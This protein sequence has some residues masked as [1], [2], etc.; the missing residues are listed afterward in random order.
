MLASVPIPC[1][2][3]NEISSLSVKKSGADVCR[4]SNLTSS[5]GKISLIVNDGNGS[6][7]DTRFQDIIEVKP[8][9]TTFL[10]DKENVS[11]DDSNEIVV[12]S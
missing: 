3:I 9:S 5:I 7:S 1:F 4:S 2:S 12:S 11:F 8:A 10:P 6:S